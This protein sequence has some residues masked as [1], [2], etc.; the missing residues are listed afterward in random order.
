MNNK[1]KNTKKTG[2]NEYPCTDSGS[3]YHTWNCGNFFECSRNE[4]YSQRQC[5][6]N[7]DHG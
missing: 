4:E 3:C 5:E 2:R 1:V 7:T 6:G